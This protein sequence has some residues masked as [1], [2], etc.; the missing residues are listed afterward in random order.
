MSRECRPAGA[1]PAERRFQRA[2]G[3]VAAAQMG[4]AAGHPLRHL[5][6]RGLRQGQ[7][8]GE[9]AHPAPGGGKG[10]ES[11][12]LRRSSAATHPI[13]ACFLFCAGGRGEAEAALSDVQLSRFPG[14]D[15]LCQL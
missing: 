5:S 3:Q 9:D 10:Q 1:D 15:L 14:A 13:H 7:L 4:G 11:C 8:D 2:E 12:P 6:N